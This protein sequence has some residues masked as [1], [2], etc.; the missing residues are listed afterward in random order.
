MSRPRNVGSGDLR[1]LPLVPVCPFA[2]TR[3]SGR[4]SSRPTPL[5]RN[6]VLTH[7][8]DDALAI[9]EAAL[10]P[11]R[12]RVRDV[13]LIESALARPR[14]S[15]FGAEAY[16]GIWLTAA[17]LLESL[18]R[19]HALVDGNKR[20]AWVACRYFLA[21]NA[22]DLAVIPAAEIDA[23]VRSVAQGQRG[24]PA[25]AVWLAAHERAGTPASLPAN[26]SLGNGRPRAGRHAEVGR[27]SGRRPRPPRPGGR[28][29]QPRRSPDGAGTLVTRPTPS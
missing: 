1:P 6:S 27:V 3:C 5:G 29:R 17:A 7:A 9:A 22:P 20:L 4:I 2:N 14:A 24:L 16:P 26:A 18:A 13:G 28:H 8:P 15:A 12:L 11:A 10:A 19:N 21:V 23:L 25:I